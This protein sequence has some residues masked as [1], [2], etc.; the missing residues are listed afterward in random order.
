MR[1]NSNPVVCAIDSSA[2]NKLVQSEYALGGRYTVQMRN[3]FEFDNETSVHKVS[4]LET[5]MSVLRFTF[6]DCLKYNN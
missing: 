5:S 4:I 2:S 6:N 3:G 1:I